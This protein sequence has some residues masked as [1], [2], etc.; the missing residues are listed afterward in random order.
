MEL[1]L[2][3]FFNSFLMV[4]AIAGGIMTGMLG[5]RLVDLSLESE[6]IL[7]RTPVSRPAAIRQ[8]QEADFQVIIKRNLFDSDA[9]EKPLEYIDLSSTSAIEPVNG[10]IESSRDYELIGTIVSGEDSLA[11]LQ[12][13]AEVNIYH[14]GETLAPGVVIEEIARKMVVL[15]DRGVKRELLLKEARGTSKTTRPARTSSRGE[16]RQG[17]VALDENRWQ[18]SKSLVENARE[19][20]NSLL[21][22]ARV[23]PELENGNT[24]GF[25]LVEMKKGSLLDQ[26]GLRV[27]DLLVEI[28]QVE[29]NSPEKALQIFQQVREANNITVGLI[30]NGLPQTF[31]YSLE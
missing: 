16:S 2:Q 3:K 27:G 21:Q 13:G 1:D 26:I 22:T 6:S 23:V 14:L 29:L 10:K 28:N 18:I 20:L 25:R 11:L 15:M 9:P 31:E 19:N 7:T 12:I 4:L 5:G 24:I 8:L 30:R 17:I